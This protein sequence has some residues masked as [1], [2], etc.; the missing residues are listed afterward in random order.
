MEKPETPPKKRTTSAKKE[1]LEAY[2]ETQKQLKEKQEADLKP[3]QKIE[4]KRSREALAVADTLSMEGIGKE[5]GN[6]RSEIGT[7]LARLS[8]RLEEE[9]GKY[10]SVKKAVEVKEKELQ[11]I[12]EIEKSALTLVALLETQQQR[13]EQFEAE[14]NEKRE[15]L[16]AEIVAKRQEWDKEVEAHDR[17]M[18]EQAAA[19]K[20]M[21]D[22]ESEEYRYQ[23][24]REQRQA[25]EQFEYEKTKLEREIQL[26]KEEMEKDLLEREKAL[27]AREGELDELRKRVE[28]FPKE[29]QAAV[30]KAVQQ[31]TE[32]LRLDA[33]SREE[34][35]K[36]EYEGE[37]RVLQ[38]RIEAFQRT[39]KEQSEQIAKLSAQLERSYGQVQ[40]IA[41]KAIE[42]S[43]GA[44]TGGN[45]P[46]RAFEPPARPPQGES[47]ML[48]K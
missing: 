26:K 16:L 23:L 29:L 39:V 20:K 24:E 34:L 32:R 8:D 17:Q 30:G 4:Q 38:S 46:S 3:E 44:R 35:L 47:E 40:D 14:L 15:T 10:L 41:V 5:I 18:K 7:M 13:R 37:Q 33:K 9:I 36:K 45:P 11:E 43:S 1:M 28:A 22:R 19:E 42:G 48:R 6:L 2:A 12:Y 31:E 27:A 21:R 25:G